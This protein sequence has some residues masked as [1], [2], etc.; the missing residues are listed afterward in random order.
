MNEPTDPLA[1][2]RAGIEYLR[3]QVVAEQEKAAAWVVELADRYEKKLDA[4]RQKVQTLTDELNRIREVATK[5]DW[6]LALRIATVL[7]KVEK[8]QKSIKT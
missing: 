7:E 4:E 3:S 8:Y 5:T 2:H 1:D 6:N